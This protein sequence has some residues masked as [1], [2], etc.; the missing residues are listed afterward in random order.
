MRVNLLDSEK[1]DILSMYGIQKTPL[2]IIKELKISKNGTHVFF[3]GKIYNTSTGDEVSLNEDFSD[4]AHTAADFASLGADFIVGGSGAIIDLLNGV[5]Y[6]IEA[7]YKPDKAEELYLLGTVTIAFAAIPGP[8]QGMSSGLKRAIKTGG[9]ALNSTEFSSAMKIIKKYSGYITKYFPTLL[10]KA[11]NSKIGKRMFDYKKR[12]SIMKSVNNY[13]RIINRKLSKK[14]PA[15]KNPETGVKTEYNKKTGKFK[16]SLIPSNIEF[17]KRFLDNFGI[18][19]S[20]KLSA[21]VGKLFTPPPPT[22]GGVIS[23]IDAN[24]I[25]IGESKLEISTFIAEYFMKGFKYE[26]ISNGLMGVASFL[27]ND[28]GQITGINGGVNSK[29]GQKLLNSVDSMV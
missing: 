9:D 10:Q 16:K 18:V 24:Y 23:K 12:R 13:V 11:L 7:M 22:G 17:D 20:T 14:T 6:F 5:S 15:K 29:E 3:D 25:Y 28:E 1:E 19:P 4:I 21:K 27:T 2:E 26:I 8:L